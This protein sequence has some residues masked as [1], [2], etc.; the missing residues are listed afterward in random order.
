METM[1][2]INYTT[3]TPVWS[4]LGRDISHC[5]NVAEALEFSGLNFTVHQ[6]DIQTSE[7]CPVPLQGYKANIK[8]DGTPLGIV[9]TKYKIVQNQDAFAFLDSLAGEGMHFER[10]G[11]LYNGRKVFILGRMPERYIMSGEHVSPYIVFI[12]SHDGTGSIKVLMT[13]IRMICLNM[14]NLALRNATRSWSAVHSGDV[15]YKLE[16]ARNTLFYA[17]QYMQ[18]LGEAVESLRQI[19]LSDKQV[20]EIAEVLIPV[21]DN[22]TAA[23]VKNANRQRQDLLERYFHAPDLIP[24]GQTAYR[25]LN[26]VTDHVNHADPIRRSANFTESR[27]S[28]SVE[29]HPMV[30]K[31]YSLLLATA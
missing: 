23:Q 26:A 3:R 17:H 24:L 31:A 20:I 13:P 25:V 4:G 22:M 12:N 15:T 2:N 19:S 5:T 8:D 7:M 6:E 16:D 10:A 11:G 1:N 21:N 18:R 28:K 29:G 27:F 9:S 30:D 14:L